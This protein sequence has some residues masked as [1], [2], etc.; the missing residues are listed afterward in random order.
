[1]TNHGLQIK[2]N[3]G[4][5]PESPT[6]FGLVRYLANLVPRWIDCLSWPERSVKGLRVLGEFQN[7]KPNL[8]LNQSKQTNRNVVGKIDA[9]D[10]L[11]YSE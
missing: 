6:R 11:A 8:E 1:M 4:K 10:R 9:I 2:R 3:A 7:E 5:I